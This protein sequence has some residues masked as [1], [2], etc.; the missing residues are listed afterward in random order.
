MRLS[1]MEAVFK[2]DN[3]ARDKFLARLFGIF[4]EE[5]VRLWGQNPRA[6]Y[7]EVGRPTIYL[8]DGKR[9][10][11]DFTFC[12]DGRYFIAEMKCELEYDNYRYLRLVSPRQLD[13]H[14][15]K[16]AFREFLR[17]NKDPSAAKVYLRGKELEVSG[18]ILVWGSITD[19]GRLQVIEE[20]GIT[21]VLSVEKCIEDLLNWQDENYL[22][23][24]KNYRQWVEELFKYLEEGV[25]FSV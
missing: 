7:R 13:H 16:P 21:D 11:L 4:S 12:K 20:T 18:C 10:T 22:R 25:L 9:Y 6:P 2:T 15:N 23:L 19:A 1:K 8:P 14:K 24:V 3:R 5:I 17:F